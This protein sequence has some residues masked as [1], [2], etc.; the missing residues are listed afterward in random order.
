MMALFKSPAA[1]GRSHA[2]QPCLARVSLLL[3]C[4]LSAPAYAFDC[5]AARSPI[6]KT[7]CADAGLLALDGTIG[8]AYG[9]LRAMGDAGA[10][11]ALASSHRAWLATRDACLK[12]EKVSA[13]LAGRM[14]RRLAYL[15][16]RPEAWPGAASHL[17]PRARSAESGEIP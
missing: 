15:T 17:V 4:A 6:E 8:K 5:K 7:I 14:S 11:A 10:R 9:A 1:Q 13:C 12:E 3:A 2:M 16:G